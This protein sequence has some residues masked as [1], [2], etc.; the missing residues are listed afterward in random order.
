VEFVLDPLWFLAR[1]HGSQ[2]QP[3]V[4]P[5]THSTPDQDQPR[6]KLDRDAGRPH[7]DLEAQRLLLDGKI[8]K[9]WDREASNQWGVLKAFEDAEFPR[10]IKNPQNLAGGPLVDER[11]R[12]TVRELNRNLKYI[13]FFCDGTKKGVSWSPKQKRRRR[14]RRSPIQPPRGR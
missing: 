8:C 10:R 14:G 9:T 2:P 4:L 13:R 3:A 11:L 6:A 12:E 5:R 1:S 7:F